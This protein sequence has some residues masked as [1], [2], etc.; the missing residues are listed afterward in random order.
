M[1]VELI[2]E[3]A[4][5]IY[6]STKPA[7]LLMQEVHVTCDLHMV[8]TSESSQG[9]F[10]LSDPH[11][12]GLRSPSPQSFPKV[13]YCTHKHGLSATHLAPDDSNHLYCASFPA[14]IFAQE[15]VSDSSKQLKSTPRAVPQEC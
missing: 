10:V 1:C 7:A 5:E 9:K 14:D 8:G 4:T 13:L 6:L 2:D 15:V 11:L 12:D 3:A